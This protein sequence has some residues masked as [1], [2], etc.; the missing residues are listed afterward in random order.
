MLSLH[1]HE[2]ENPISEMGNLILPGFCSYPFVLLKWGIAVLS[3]S[4]WVLK[5]PMA[6]TTYTSF[7]NATL[8]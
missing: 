4:F 1:T 2:E 7:F 6:I 3:H 8:P 5:L